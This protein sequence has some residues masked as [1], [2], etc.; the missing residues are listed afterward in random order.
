M[1]PGE[2]ERRAN[3]R[4]RDRL[5]GVRVCSF[6]N[7]SFPKTRRRDRF[8]ADPRRSSLCFSSIWLLGRLGKTL[9]SEFN[10]R[11]EEVSFRGWFGWS[12]GDGGA[13]AR[14][15]RIRGVVTGPVDGEQP[16]QTAAA[17]WQLRA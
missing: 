3:D 10:R 9:A 14:I 12:S 16:K 2:T 4:L 15:E 1:T 17:G 5:R 13:M 7:G 11:S 8:R 6:P